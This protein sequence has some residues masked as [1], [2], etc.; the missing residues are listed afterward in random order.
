MPE[1]KQKETPKRVERFIYSEDD[2]NHIFK[3]GKTG[4]VFSGKEN[5]VK[6]IILLKKLITK[7]KKTNK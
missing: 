2:I 6:E 1:E 7:T 4:T 5:E 3:L